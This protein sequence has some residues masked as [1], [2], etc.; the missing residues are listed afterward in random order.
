MFEECALTNVKLILQRF[1]KSSWCKCDYI[2]MNYHGFFSPV[3]ITVFD[4][5]SFKPL[6]SSSTTVTSAH[7]SCN[8]LFPFVWSGSNQCG[9]QSKQEVFKSLVILEAIWCIL[10]MTLLTI[11][12]KKLKYL[13]FIIDPSEY[14]HT[15]F[16][17]SFILFHCVVT[18]YCS[19]GFISFL[20]FFFI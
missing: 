1:T 18:I 17:L 6:L 7:L 19:F 13:S 4:V 15:F 2:R 14:Q 3:T 5:T 20:K 11:L 12:W 8:R 10:H 9:I 16:S